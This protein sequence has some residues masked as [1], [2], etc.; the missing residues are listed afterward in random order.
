MKDIQFYLIEAKKREIS[1]REYPMKKKETYGSLGEKWFDK[2][3][4]FALAG[5]TAYTKY[6]IND[7]NGFLEDMDKEFK[8]GGEGRWK[9]DCE[10][11]W[12]ICQAIKDGDLENAVKLAK[13]NN[14]DKFTYGAHPNA[15]YTYGSYFL[16]TYML[17]RTYQYILDGNLVIRERI[18]NTLWDLDSTLDPWYNKFIDLVHKLEKQVPGHK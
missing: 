7:F 12:K 16:D 6:H 8:P 5:N 15:D 18:L 2:C 17:L 10:V 13:E 3:K 14:I 11:R 1:K 9:E 4:D